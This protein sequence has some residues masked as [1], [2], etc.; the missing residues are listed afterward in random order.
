[1]FSLRGLN[2]CFIDRIDPES[3]AFIEIEDCFIK[4]RKTLSLSRY[5]LDYLPR[6][7]VKLKGAVTLRRID[8][9]FNQFST[10]PSEIGLLSQ[11]QEF[12]LC[13]NSRIPFQ[14]P[15]ELGKL[16]SLLNLRVSWNAL[17]ELPV[18]ICKINSL[19][20]LDIGNNQIKKLPKEFSKLQKLAVIK[21]ENNLFT[22]FPKKLQCKKLNHLTLSHNPLNTSNKQWFDTISDFTELNQLE[23]RG[24]G[25][26]DWPVQIS[27]LSSLGKLDMGDNKIANIP[28]GC[29][30]NLLSLTKLFLDKN[31]LTELPEDFGNNLTSLDTLNLLDNQIIELPFSFRYLINLQQFDINSETIKM[32]PKEIIKKG[33]NEIRRFIDSLTDEKLACYRIKLLV[34]GKENVGK[35][36]LIKKLQKSSIKKS[37]NITQK[38]DTSSG[39]ATSISTDGIDIDKLDFYSK[40]RGKNIE[41]SAWDFAGQGFF[42][43]LNYSLPPPLPPLF[44]SPTTPLALLLNSNI[45][46]FLHSTSPFLSFSFPLYFLF[47]PTLLIY[48]GHPRSISSLLFIR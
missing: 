43:F 41:F 13:F 27:K 18:E 14:L 19:K 38:V 45:S 25:I 26:E 3:K 28:N 23:L 34:V 20:L 10:L 12:K 32:P 33:L 37:K 4:K 21:M 6:E 30:S 31:K 46:I 5:N 9:S 24:C 42:Q 1:M 7:I 44:F 17:E 48:E 39:S 22:K 15:T 35:T 8:L 16:T 29:F 36:S 40:D 2:D 47:L 11:I